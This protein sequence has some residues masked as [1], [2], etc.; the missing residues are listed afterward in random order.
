MTTEELEIVDDVSELIREKYR[1]IQ[2]R[3][4]ERDKATKTDR[5]LLSRLRVVLHDGLD[6]KRPR[7][8]PERLVDRKV[9]LMKWLEAHG[10]GGKSVFAPYEVDAVAT[11]FGWTRT[12]VMVCCHNHPKDFK[13]TWRR[14]VAY[15]SL[16]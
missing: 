10:C 11:A 15:V 8:A 14:N 13:L 9:P 4:A 6:R 16:R 2:S 5:A 3:I 1:Q 12:Q 7:K